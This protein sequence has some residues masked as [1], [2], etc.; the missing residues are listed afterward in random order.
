[1]STPAGPA[2]IL[3]A[4]MAVPVAERLDALAVAIR[5]A[6]DAGLLDGYP[7]TREDVTA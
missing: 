7:L 5:A 1:M 2:E 6:L 3:A 4:L